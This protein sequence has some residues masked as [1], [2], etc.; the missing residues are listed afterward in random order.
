MDYTDDACMFV[1][2]DGQLTRMDNSGRGRRSVG[3]WVDL[4]LVVA[5][6]SA[7]AWSW[8]RQWG[9]FGS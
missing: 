1:F 2:S 4:V 6:L 9:N 8:V 5:A 7:A 3:V